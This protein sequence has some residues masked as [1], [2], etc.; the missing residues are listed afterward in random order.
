MPKTIELT[1][2]ELE[3]LKQLISSLSF[4]PTHQQS[5]QNLNL[6]IRILN[7]LLEEKK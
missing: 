3:F 6:S 5:E 7:K 1:Q 4:S 2:L